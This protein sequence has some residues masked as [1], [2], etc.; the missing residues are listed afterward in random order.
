MKILEQRDGAGVQAL[1]VQRVAQL[2]ALQWQEDEA[3][4]TPEGV[5]RGQAEAV[6]TGLLTESSL[7]A[8]VARVLTLKFEL[9]LFE[10]PRLPSPE[11][12]A[13]VV[14]SSEHT[15][16][17]LEAARRSALGRCVPSQPWHWARACGWASTTSMPRSRW[18]RT[19]SGNIAR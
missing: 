9:G 10:N 19:S 5:L 11:R 18:W 12:I 4:A 3:A 7:D 8:A 16:L 1:G 14:G 6:Q 2:V 13:A 15:S 17:N